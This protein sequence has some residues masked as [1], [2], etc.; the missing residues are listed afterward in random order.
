MTLEDI[1][2]VGE[3]IGSLAIVISLLYVAIEVRRNSRL[4]RLATSQSNTENTVQLLSAIAHSEQSA[5]TLRLGRQ[6]PAEL[7]PDEAVQFNM[8]MAAAVFAIQNAYVHHMENASAHETWDGWIGVATMFLETP[9]G[10][11]W[12]GSGRKTLD[13]RFVSYAEQKWPALREAVSPE[14]GDW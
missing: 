2:N 13:R 8:Y 12:W 14:S 10:R 4:T 9:G 3:L 11:L 5:R 1:G 7:N 6:D